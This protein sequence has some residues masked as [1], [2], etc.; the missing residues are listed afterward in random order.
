[1][2]NAKIRHLMATY[3][4]E[5]PENTWLS[6]NKTLQ[7]KP[8]ELYDAIRTV[9]FKNPTTTLLLSIFLGGLGVDRFYIG[10]VGLGVA[11]LL[12][13]W[14]TMFIWPF[15]DI[16]ISYKACK[17]KNYASLMQVIMGY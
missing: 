9:K 17:N 1:M 10:D 7:D 16:F 14:L 4:K 3:K 8:D 12:F 5:L 13:G 2:D 15:I 11:K 6:L